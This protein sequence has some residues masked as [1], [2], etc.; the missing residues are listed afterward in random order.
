ML[1]LKYYKM[2]PTMRNI[3]YR[4]ALKSPCFHKHSSIITKGY[5]K[6]ILAGHNS[7]QRTISR[8][9]IACCLHAEMDAIRKFEQCYLKSKKKKPR[10]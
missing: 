6:F 1:N 10:F 4:E 3:A 5:S 7:N 8:K 9:K 2:N